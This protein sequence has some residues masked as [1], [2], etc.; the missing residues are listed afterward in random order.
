MIWPYANQQPIPLHLGDILLPLALHLCSLPWAAGIL[1]E[2][3][4]KGK[5]NI[6]PHGSEGFDLRVGVAHTLEPSH[7]LS[8]LWVL[9][10]YWP[11]ARTH[12]PGYS[13]FIPLTADATAGL[14]GQWPCFQCSASQPSALALRR[15]SICIC[16][17]SFSFH[18]AHSFLPE[19]QTDWQ[20]QAR[21]AHLVPK[22]DFT[23]C[24]S[25]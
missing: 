13:S 25:K 6:R 20:D 19:K 1:H 12:I 11:R 22:R 10:C 7:P 18:P 9:N 23:H 15:R 24:L 2:A 16:F 14:S 5:G 4:T 21:H 17:S 8:W 3:N